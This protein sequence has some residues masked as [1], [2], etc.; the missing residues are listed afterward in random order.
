MF[1]KQL[2]SS[3]T[4][5]HLGLSIQDLL[6]KDCKQIVG[7]NF[8]LIMSSLPMN[9]TVEVNLCVFYNII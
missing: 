4:V 1:L 9:Y 2:H 7:S 8:R 5:Q 3:P 6:Q